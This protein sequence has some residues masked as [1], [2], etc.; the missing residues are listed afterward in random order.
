MKQYTF[1]LNFGYVESSSL[2]YFPFTSTGKY[3]DAKEALVALATW[4]REE[5]LKPMQV[6][7][8]KCCEA[9]KSKDPE[10]DFCS[11]CRQSLHDHEFDSESFEEWLREMAGCDIDSFHSNYIDYDEDD[12]WQTGLLEGAPNPRFVYNAEWVI[13][14][15]LGHP[16]RSDRTFEDICKDRTKKKIESFSYYG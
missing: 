8:K 9:T 10:A 1:V 3:K 15:A 12:P 5:Y 7:L 16:H 4:L 11:K 13:T 14:A 6:K 2:S